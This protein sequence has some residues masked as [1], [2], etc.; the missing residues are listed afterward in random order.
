MTERALQIIEIL[1]RGWASYHKHVVSARIFADIDSE[2]W[3]MLWR[4][5]CRR[6]PNKGLRWVKV[7]DFH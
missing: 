5:A 1:L 7:R 3:C 4:W 6:H 2:V